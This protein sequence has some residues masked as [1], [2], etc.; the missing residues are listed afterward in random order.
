MD[1]RLVLRDLGARHGTY[2][3]GDRVGQRVLNVGDTIRI[4]MTD[5]RLRRVCGVA[6]PKM[7]DMGKT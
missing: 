5:V 1:G 6:R 7:V 4:G 3:N 2:V